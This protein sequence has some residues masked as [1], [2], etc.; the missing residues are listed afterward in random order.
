MSA[1]LSKVYWK[2]WLLQGHVQELN[3]SIDILQSTKLCMT[4]VTGIF[5]VFQRKQMQELKKFIA[6]N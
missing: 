1:I 4:L 3:E 5:W 2:L 6:P